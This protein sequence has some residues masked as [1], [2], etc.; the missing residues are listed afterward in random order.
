M[1]R[2]THTHTHTHTH[3]LD[4][5]DWAYNCALCY[6]ARLLPARSLARLTTCKLAIPLVR[7][8]ARLSSSLFLAHQPHADCN[9]LAGELRKPWLATAEPTRSS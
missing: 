6:G 9:L 1:E 5:A 8:V 4:N 2:I 3:I 7:R